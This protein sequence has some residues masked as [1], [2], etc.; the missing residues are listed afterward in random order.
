MSSPALSR[1]L[2]SPLVA[3][4][5]H[6]V[7][8]PPDAVCFDISSSP[9]DGRAR[10]E[11]IFDKPRPPDDWT[12]QLI[13]QRRVARERLA[14]EVEEIDGG[15]MVAMSNP[16]VLA[17]RLEAYRLEVEGEGREAGR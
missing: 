8:P 10:L 11:V 1:G 15:H 12:C 13:F 2:A 14:I 16:A 4:P 5:S 7:P 9:G 3:R 17:D 6:A